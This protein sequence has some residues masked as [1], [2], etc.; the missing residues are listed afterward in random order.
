MD[1][2]MTFDP[3]SGAD[4]ATALRPEETPTVVQSPGSAR[5]RE[6]RLIPGTLLGDRYRIVAPLGHGG[7]GEVYRAEDLKLGQPI[8]LK[9]LT[10][11]GAADPGLERRLHEEVRIGRQISHPNVCR[12][13][14]I[15]D[16]DGSLFITMEYVDGEDLASLLRRIGRLAPDKALSLAR[17]LCAGLAAAHEKGVIHRD[18]KPANVMVDGR[19]RARI[20]DF[21]LAIGEAESGASAMAGTPAYMAPEQL[22]DQPASSKSDIYAL[23][24]I[25]YEIFTG[26]RVFEATSLTEIIQRQ[27]DLLITRPTAIVPDISPAVERVILQCLEP[28]PS[29]RP[30]SVQAI[31]RELPGFDPL[32][33][34]LA[35]GETPSPAM[36]AAAERTVSFPLVAAWATLL[37]VLAGL[38][39]F[40]MVARSTK[41]YRIVPVKPPEVLLEGV[42]EILAATGITQAPADSSFHFFPDRDQLNSPVGAGAGMPAPI[43]FLYRQSPR[44]LVPENTLKRVLTEDPPLNVS[45]MVSVTLDATGRLVELVVVPPQREAAGASADVDWTRFFDYA[46]IDSAGLTRVQPEW[47]APVDT[48]RKQA[49]MADALRI[50]AASYHG[51][52]VWFSLI[53][54]WQTPAGMVARSPSSI[55]LAT[56]TNIAF[57][58]TLPIAAALLAWRNWRRGQGDRRGAARVAVVSFVCWLILRAASAHHVADFV[59]E[60]LM[61]SR[62]IADSTFWTLQTWVMYIAVEPFIRR[63]WPEMLISWTRVL[64]GRFA[65]PLVARDVLVGAAAG[66]LVAGAA[67]VTAIAPAWFGLPASPPFVP[68][69]LAL[70]GLRFVAGALSSALMEAILRAVAGAALLL[71]LQGITRSRS[72]MWIGSFLVMAAGSLDETTGGIGFRI[73]FAVLVA[74]AALV[75]ALRFGLLT[76]CAT[77]FFIRALQNVPITLDPSAWYFGRSAVT[78]LLLTAIA[79]AAFAVS[80]RGKRWLPRIAFEG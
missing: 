75:L 9:F 69:V 55:S 44:P 16:V 70:T 31:V 53:G 28:D 56:A 36:V 42:K 66:V 32:A 57:L 20:T 62:F 52:P 71:L 29:M 2:P 13:Y 61:L 58:I 68:G 79:T 78:L 37:V 59:P 64:S 25:F 49:W 6:R 40:A 26:R 3:Q 72:A 10:R 41:L 18:L 60:W 12:L 7:M 34:A 77:S 22:A 47:T 4:E 11:G 63:R 27:R 39:G 23:G 45:G 65:D 30:D 73:A 48:D 8:A 5:A 54:P 21:G 76:I 43:R 38:V 15:A 14:D 50:E 19:G 35:L 67:Q 24:L 46:R 33:A 51:R 74:T 17:D 1:A 80:Q